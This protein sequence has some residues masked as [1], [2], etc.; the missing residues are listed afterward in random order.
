M[1]HGYMAAGYGCFARTTTASP[2][3]RLPRPHQEAATESRG[4]RNPVDVTGSREEMNKGVCLLVQASA[5]P[6]WTTTHRQPRLSSSCLVIPCMIVIAS[7]DSGARPA[8]VRPG[9]VETD[10]GALVSPAHSIDTSSLTGKRV[11][12]S[13]TKPHCHH[14]QVDSTVHAR[15]HS[16][17][18]ISD[19]DEG[20]LELR[21]Q[22]REAEFCARRRRVRQRSTAAM[23]NVDSVH[24]KSPRNFLIILLRKRFMAKPIVKIKLLR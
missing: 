17:T 10:P 3:L 8:R 18:P 20:G 22:I 24:I 4:M 11:A 9:R 7:L 15:A 6:S 2:G 23:A 21:G 13:Q 16:Y 1:D 19:D 14:R 5:R 12:R